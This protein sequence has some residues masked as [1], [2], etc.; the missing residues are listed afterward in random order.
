MRLQATLCNRANLA[1]WL[2]PAST[3]KCNALLAGR[4]RHAHSLQSMTD[5]MIAA[6]PAMYASRLYLIRTVHAD[7]RPGMTDDD[8]TILVEVSL[9]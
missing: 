2:D 5:R 3:V 4:N 1:V 7:D 8:S 6:A 9:Q